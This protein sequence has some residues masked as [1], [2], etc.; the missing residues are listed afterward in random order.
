MWNG[1]LHSAQERESCFRFPSICV[2]AFCLHKK[3]CAVC[4]GLGSRWISALGVLW[5]SGSVTKRMRPVLDCPCSC[6]GWRVTFCPCRCR[7]AILLSF[8]GGR[9][10][11]GKTLKGGF[12]LKVLAIL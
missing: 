2:G 8:F 3:Q 1:R 9:M 6:G 12:S 10:R 4:G 5:L 7:R 11:M